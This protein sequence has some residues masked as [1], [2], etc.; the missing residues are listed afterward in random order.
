M[1]AMAFIIGCLYARASLLS[2][3]FLAAIFSVMLLYGGGNILNDYFDREIDSVNK[4]LKESASSGKAWSILTFLASLILSA[5]AGLYFFLLSLLILI[6]LAYYARHSK[7]LG[8]WK[9]LFVAFTGSLVFI[10]G[11]ILGG[12]PGHNLLISIISVF[13]I[14]AR[15]IIKDIEDMEGDSLAGARTLP[16]RHGVPAAIGSANIATLLGLA[17]S[18]LLFLQGSFRTFFLYFIA[19]SLIVL[20]LGNLRRKNSRMKQFRRHIEAIMIVIL[21]GA[22]LAQ[23]R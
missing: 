4:T 11:S 23:L 1:I 22:V 17:L 21:T 6:L 12:E 8:L 16:I 18:L 20:I 7:S 2:L 14:M 15:E 3:E 9:N 19:A 10:L 5:F 13:F